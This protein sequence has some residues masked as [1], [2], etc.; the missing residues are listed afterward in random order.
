[1]TPVTQTILDGRSGN[2]LAAAVCSVFD[3]PDRLDELTA[4]LASRG[5]VFQFDQLRS[6]LRAELGMTCSYETSWIADLTQ[7]PPSSRPPHPYRVAAVDGAVAGAHHAV[8]E[9]AGEIVWCPNPSRHGMK[10]SPKAM[11]QFYDLNY[12][13][14]E[15]IGRNPGEGRQVSHIY[16]DDGSGDLEPLCRW[17]WNRSDGKGFSIFRGHRGGKGLCR[18]CAR[19][20]A[21]GEVQGPGPSNRKTKWI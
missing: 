13:Y 7:L 6:W 14:V 4:H 3:C 12:S 19:R 11:I 8:V 17:G 5:P 16:V 20:M 15:A 1:M 10:K 18:V 9:H 2:C 21:A